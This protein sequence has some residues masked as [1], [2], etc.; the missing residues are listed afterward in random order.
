MAYEY[1]PLK[2]RTFPTLKQ[3]SDA[4]KRADN[5][6]PQ[7]R[8]VRPLMAILNAMAER[9][10]RLAG[11]ILTRKAAVCSYKWTVKPYETSDQERAD[12]AAARCR[13]VINDVLGWHIDRHLYGAMA[14]E[15]KWITGTP[16][17]TAPK[18]IKSYLPTEVEKNGRNAEDVAILKG[19]QEFERF[20]PLQQDPVENWLIDVDDRTYRGGILRT[21][22]FHEIL[23]NENIQEWA[24]FNKKLKGIIQARFEQWATQEE[25]ENAITA[26]KQL[27]EHNYSATSK[28]TEFVFNKTADYLGAA[29]FKDFKRELEQDRA[30]TILGQANTPSLPASGGSRA[31]LQVQSMIT[32]DIHHDSMVTAEQFT[33]DQLLL[34]DHRL[35][36]EPNATDAPYYLEISLA[37][38]RDPE[39][40]ARTIAYAKQAAIPVKKAEVYERLQYTQPEEGEDAFDWSNAGGMIL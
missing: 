11:H 18:I 34:H 1:A 5:A 23:I 17:G 25:K 21:L 24:A 2:Q 31:A 14:V 6:D 26:L 19:D 13:R 22:A 33:T 36:A 29:G 3:A 38:D 12:K 27:A 10:T 35:N 39:K 20:Y 4:L 15:L 16:N 28:A 9:S 40:E 37:E 30:I 32:A 7:A 8:D